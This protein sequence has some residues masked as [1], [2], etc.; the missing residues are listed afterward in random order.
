MASKKM[1]QKEILNPALAV[2]EACSDFTLTCKGAVWILRRC[3]S[4]NKHVTFR[5]RERRPVLTLQDL[6]LFNQTKR[7]YQLLRIHPVISIL[8]R[9]VDLR[10]CHEF[11]YNMRRERVEDPRLF[12]PHTEVR[13]KF[14]WIKTDG[15]FLK[16]LLF[17]FPFLM[18]LLFSLIALFPW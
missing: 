9:T 6:L 3:H 14:V 16:R 7:K 11:A 8:Q 4:A 15:A 17:F 13:K 5:G 18:Q 2:S 10:C 12:F 1:P